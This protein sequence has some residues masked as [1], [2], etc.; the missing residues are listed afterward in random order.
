MTV[1]SKEDFTAK[2]DI[3][4]HYSEDLEAWIAK[5]GPSTIHLVAGTNS[6]SG[7]SV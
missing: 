3:E 1:L 6:D 4:T 2:H 7:Y 5:Y